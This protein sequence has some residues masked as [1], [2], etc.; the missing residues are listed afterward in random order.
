MCQENTLHTITP[1]PAWTIGGRMDPCFHVVYT[2]FW[3]NHLIVAAEIE[4]HQTID[5]QWACE[6]R[7]LIFLFLADRSDTGVFF[8]CCSSSASRFDMLCV[9]RCSSADLGWNDWIFELLLP[10]HQSLESPFPILMLSLNF[11]RSSDHV[12]MPKC[13]ELLTCDWL[14]RY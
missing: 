13:I 6:N 5:K 1:P 7:S 12:Y 11:S 9:Q 14:I 3:P 4:I 10:F 2:K 8:C